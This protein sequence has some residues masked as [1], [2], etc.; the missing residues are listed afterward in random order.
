MYEKKLYEHA[1]VDYNLALE[2][3]NNNLNAYNNR[4][5]AWFQKKEFDQAMS[6][7]NRAIELDSGYAK[8]YNNRG[9]VWYDKG[10]NDLMCQSFETACQLGDCK[11]L[12]RV[13]KDNLCR[14]TNPARLD[15]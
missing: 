14:E 8:A 6:D 5:L 15:K 7:F 2:L 11:K 4:G 10:R 12:R 9:M 1:I 13:R 3:D